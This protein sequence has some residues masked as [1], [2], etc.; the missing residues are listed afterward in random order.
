[1]KNARCVDLAA[2]PALP[3]VTTDVC[4]IGAGAAGLYLG[5]ELVRHGVDFVIVEAGG[6]AASSPAEAG[7]VPLFA[8]EAYSGA[9]EGRSFGL[10]GSTTRW[11][12]A[13]V[14][15]GEHDLRSD[16][17]TDTWHRITTEVD[18]HSPTVLSR[19][20]WE[21]GPDFAD[22]A[23]GRI[24]APV[25]ALARS[26]LDVQA[27][28]ILPFRRKNFVGL[29]SAFNTSAAPLVLVNAVAKDWTI[30]SGPRSVPHVTGV[31]AVSR[32]GNRVMVQA[33][34]FVVAAGA[35]ESARILL[36]IQE[37]SASRMFPSRAVPGRRLGDHLSVPV[38]DF[39]PD[40]HDRVSAL[41]APRFVGGWMR[42]FR[43]LPKDQFKYMPRCFA[44]LIFE[45][46][47]PGFRMAK[48]ALGAVQARRRPKLSLPKVVSGLGALSLLAFDRVAR[49]RLHVPRGSTVRLQLDV[50]QVD[51]EENM[52]TL[53]D[54]TDDFGRRR[55]RIDWDV[56]ERDRKMIGQA[57]HQ[58]LS[59]WQSGPFGLPRLVPRALSGFEA[60]PHDAYH[61]VGTCWMGCETDGVVDQHLQV[62]GA[63][64][65]WVLSTGVLPTAGSANPTFT[66]LC[67]A[68]GL[69]Q[70]L[71]ADLR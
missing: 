43:F 46:D 34:R 24:P 27:A 70:R 19:L 57:A 63:K 16:E 49:S 45:Q 55:V 33:R 61:P 11:G 6:L 66:M 56:T 68:Q 21:N 15:H 5:A 37:C 30:E 10:G 67:L 52:I 41:F 4:I 13:L 12:G 60:K 29:W 54:E 17:H 25:A 65:L 3:A 7:F 58:L 69:A 64:G 53:G 9:T 42:S 8:R 47:S 32:N 59:R 22:Y 50:E 14:P 20:G 23:W 35:I 71:R 44:H 40:D 48:E 18:E 36:E 31:V 38:A 2:H 28:L 26:G 39:L 62:N 1:V 51:T